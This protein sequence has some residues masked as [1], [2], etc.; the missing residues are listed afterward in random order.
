[1]GRATPSPFAQGIAVQL[2][3]E[4]PTRTKTL[5]FV[6]AVLYILLVFLPMRLLS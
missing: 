5:V 4:H 3:A 6:K 2:A 1:L